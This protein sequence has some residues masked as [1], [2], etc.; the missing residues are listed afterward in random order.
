MEVLANVQRDAQDVFR[1]KPPDEIG[2]SLTAWP[3]YMGGSLLVHGK[4]LLSVSVPHDEASAGTGWVR[5]PTLLLR[6]SLA[7]TVGQHYSI[8]Y[9][10]G[11][12]NG[13]QQN[14]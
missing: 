1:G 11:A 7:N 6:A 4:N 5:L 2:K 14:P 9:C 12:G 10:G 13:H 8:A 3:T